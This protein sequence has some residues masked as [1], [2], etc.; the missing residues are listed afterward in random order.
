MARLRQGEEV[1]FPLCQIYLADGARNAASSATIAGSHP[2]RSS[3]LAI[4]SDGIALE[5]GYYFS[6]GGER[7]HL[8][9]D[10]TPPGEDPV[11]GPW[12]DDGTSPWAS[13]QS[14]WAPGRPAGSWLVSIVPPIRATVVDGSI[15][16]F[17][18]LRLRCVP[19]EI[20]DGDL[21]LDLG[22]FGSP[23]LTL[24]ESL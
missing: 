12:V 8:I 9:T 1:I 5:P 2:L 7:L 11:G 18:N 15:V 17:K 24:I 14:P 6:L 13:S 23:N 10:V 20:S 19:Q 4:F 21:Q 3:K 22:R 16:D